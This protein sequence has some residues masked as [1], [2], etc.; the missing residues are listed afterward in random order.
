MSLY[1]N[2]YHVCIRRKDKSI[3]CAR[4]NDYDAMVKCIAVSASINQITIIA[5]CIMSNHIHILVRYSKDEEFNKFTSAL[6]R[7]YSRYL[8]KEYGDE[9]SFKRQS[10]I[11]VK[12]IVSEKHLKNSL[13]YILNNPKDNGCQD[14]LSYEWSSARCLYVSGQPPVGSINLKEFN[15]LECRA[16]LKAKK[17]SQYRNW[18]INKNQHLEP[19][20]FC[21]W[22]SAEAI[23][24]NKNNLLSALDTINMEYLYRSNIYL[25]INKLSDE[26]LYLE[27]NNIAKSI[28]SKNYRDLYKLEAYR[29]IRIVKKQYLTTDTQLARILRLPIHEINGL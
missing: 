9:H 13:A 4:P 11:S 16:I 15:I 14:V 26:E 7:S 8:N 25:P 1:L 19:C 5:Y 28:Y 18:W 6:M 24:G 17:V 22:E 29:I 2:T 3:L 23:Y 10:E 12:S 27:I 21:D 20:S